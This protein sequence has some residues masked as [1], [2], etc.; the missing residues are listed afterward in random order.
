M[1]M[2][3]DE[4]LTILQKFPQQSI[5]SL[6]KKTF[7]T[8]DEGI[9]KA[10]IIEDGTTAVIAFIRYEDQKKLNE[11]NNETVIIKR[12]KL[13]VANCGDARAIIITN[14]S[15]NTSQ[16]TKLSNSSQTLFPNQ[17]FVL[18]TRLSFD[19]KPTDASEAQRIWQLNEQVKQEKEEEKLNKKN[20]DNK[21]KRY[22]YEYQERNLYEQY[23]DQG[24][25]V[26]QGR[27]NGILAISR[28][29]G[30][31]YLKRAVI[32]DPYIS[33]RLIRDNELNVMERVLDD[34]GERIVIRKGRL[35]EE[36]KD[37]INTNIDNNDLMDEHSDERYQNN[38]IDVIVKDTFLI[39]AC[40]GLWD[41]MTDDE[42]AE[43]VSHIKGDAQQI[44]RIL[45][46]EAL[47]RG[48]TD[49]VT[50]LVVKL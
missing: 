50:V 32:S 20:K 25:F 8:V 35:N 5:S 24:Y 39:L 6:I 31:H 15:Y 19:H 40:D 44:A 16:L 12:R 30:D 17:P 22:G 34:E 18:S 21:Q 46:Q 10:G 42:V 26:Y 29:L 36:K 23:T 2:Q 43:F 11:L 45:V 38:K 7:S 33:T 41:V 3:G 13:Y 47:K 27:V 37:N 28:S 9:L 14:I 48:T 4:L 1:G 49:N